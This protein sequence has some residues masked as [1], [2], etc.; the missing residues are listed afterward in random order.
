MMIALTIAAVA[1]RD[2]PA[3]AATITGATI[4]RQGAAVELQFAVHGRGL[5]W[6]LSAHGQQ[7]WID[8]AHVR[9]Q[10]PARPLG[11]R[12]L[13]PIT[14]VESIDAGAGTARIVVEVTGRTD[15]A[16]GRVAH[17]LILRLAPAGAAPDLA[18]PLL[19]RM[20]HVRAPAA[21]FFPAGEARNRAAAAY[22][23]SLRRASPAAMR[24]PLDSGQAAAD[25]AQAQTPPASAA[26]TARG[27]RPLVV[28]DAGHGGHDPGT[29]AAGDVAEKDLALAIAIRVARALVARG[30]D[31]RLTRASDVFLTLAERTQ[32]ANRAGA[33]LFVSIHLNSSPD[34][35]ASGIETYYLNNTTDR[36]TIRLARMENGVS[37]GYGAEGEPNLNY[38]LTDMRQQYKANEAASLARMIEAETVADIDASMGLKVNELGAMQGPFYVLVGALM[39]AVLIECGFLSNS[40]E[41]R[42]LESVQYQQALADGVARA[43]IH[44][45]NGDAAVGNL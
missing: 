20:E 38:I 9:M 33:D 8:L 40:G 34:A 42:L 3:R 18:A 17:R 10:I 12:E 19:M 31:A 11:G 16:I 27:T 35:A 44:Y 28:I 22:P 21:G 13:D 5:G 1:A 14:S 26:E 43:V 23:N 30:V 37:G 6:H 32:M 29:E 2:T 25:A 45:F 36:A 39:P 4:E 15:Y 41:A 7:L 24:A